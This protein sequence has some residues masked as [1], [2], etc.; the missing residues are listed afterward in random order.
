MQPEPVFHKQLFTLE[1][2][3]RAPK[4]SYSVEELWEYV[5]SSYFGKVDALNSTQRIT[6]EELQTAK[7]QMKKRIPEIPEP[8]RVSLQSWIERHGAEVVLVACDL[9][10]QKEGYPSLPNLPFF[11]TEAK[12]IIKREE[13]RGK[14]R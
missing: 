13:I 5:W 2:G 6:E 10:L 3:R 11:F 1:N 14:V 12:G 9:L 8:Q 7:E 4:S